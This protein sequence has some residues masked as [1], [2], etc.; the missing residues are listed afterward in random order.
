MFR[1]KFD[2]CI[3]TDYRFVNILTYLTV[4]AFKKSFTKCIVFVTQKM[5]TSKSRVAKHKEKLGSFLVKLHELLGRGR[6][7]DRKRRKVKKNFM[8]EKFSK[9]RKLSTEKI[10]VMLKGRKCL[11]KE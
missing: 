4:V 5:K 2:S 8:R 10:S 1:R 7:Y 6:E 3:I 9:E 11:E